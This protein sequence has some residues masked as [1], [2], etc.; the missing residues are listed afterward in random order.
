MSFLSFLKSSVLHPLFG[1][2]PSS[3][4]RSYVQ[5]QVTEGKIPLESVVG[6]KAVTQEEMAEVFSR[7]KIDAFLYFGQWLPVESTNVAALQYNPEKSELTVEY[8]NGGIYQYQNVSIREADSF[9]RAMSKGGWVW[10]H[11][12]LR[13]KGN[14]WAFRKP[15]Q[16]ISGVSA[17]QPQWMRK[18]SI[19]LLHGKVGSEGL[20]N[21]S[22][23]K[24]LMPRGTRK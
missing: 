24:I 12:R 7:D 22:W 18:K 16:F 11:L 13:G 10:D 20:R 23:A 4:F 3:G 21:K 15:Y 6:P 2:T 8:K 5:R 19:R 9:A 1:K 14:F 17:Y